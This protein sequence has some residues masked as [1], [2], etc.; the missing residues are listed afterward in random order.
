MK[1]LYE[2]LSF[3]KTR[4]NK[5]ILNQ[6]TGYFDMENLIINMNTPFDEKEKNEEKEA[7]N[8]LLTIKHEKNHWVQFCSSTLGLIYTLIYE[9]ENNLIWNLMVKYDY[10]Y[11]LINYINKDD[12][13]IY[14]LYNIAEVILCYLEGT[15]NA[16]NINYMKRF[17]L[18]KMFN[19]LWNLI[20][21]ELLVHNNVFLHTSFIDNFQ[22]ILKHMNELDKYYENKF[23]LYQNSK[24]FGTIDL[25]EGAARIQDKLIL[26]NRFKNPDRYINLLN[27][28]L[29]YENAE[30]MFDE[31]FSSDAFKDLYGFKK[32][33]IL[34][35]IDYAIN[36]TSPLDIGNR[37]FY[38]DYFLY[39]Y[40]NILPI[41]RYV[42]LILA[43]KEL[44]ENREVEITYLY[45]QN[46]EVKYS[47]ELLNEFINEI[48]SKLEQKTGYDNPIKIARNFLNDGV[49]DE[50]KGDLFKMHFTNFKKLCE[51]RVEC[52]LFIVSSEILNNYDRKLYFK[53]FKK[54]NI[55]LKI[56]G[57]FSNINDEN[58]IFVVNSIVCN[59]LNNMLFEDKISLELLSKQNSV[60]PTYI[61][62]ILQQIFK[63]DKIDN[64][65]KTQ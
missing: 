10:K 42:K 18:G 65:F 4:K 39:P 45:N 34:M 24:L 40:N 51:I 9:L 20:I 54:L 62:Y 57:K 52:P 19:I 37:K 17:E 28:D 43:F 11:P 38:E 14:S 56:D 35:L 33:F 41:N 31:C 59:F 61:L 16:E 22:Q 63:K 36:F 6:L 50:T 60:N 12:E 2:T 1:N 7:L 53:Y 27:H 46:G 8:N 47:I 44:L 32:F 48:Y 49:A 5:P 26:Y 13:S 64:I 30:I 55:L 25:L 21:P 15:S 23:A 3:L 29:K 58:E